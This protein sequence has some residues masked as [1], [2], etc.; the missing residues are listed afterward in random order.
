MKD[1]IIID[2]FFMRSLANL[3]RDK[4]GKILIR[5]VGPLSLK[6]SLLFK[7]DASSSLSSLALTTIS[8]PSGAM[9]FF[10]S[11]LADSSS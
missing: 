2:F 7:L 6:A 5:L 9:S 3:R 1:D 10:I 4:D 11:F 8:G